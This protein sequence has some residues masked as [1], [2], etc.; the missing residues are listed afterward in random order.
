M[1]N[2]QLNFS[3]AYHPQIDGQTEAVNRS[4]GNLLRCLVGEH[5]KSWDKKLSQAEFAHNHAV[6]SSTG[7]SPFQVV[8]TI[9]PRGPLNLLPFPKTVIPHRTT[10]D[11]VNSLQTIHEAVRNNLERTTTKYKSTADKKKRHMEF[12]EGD[13]VWAV[14]TKERFPT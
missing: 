10:L 2:T 4:L 12:N 6:N 3:S 11:F 5:M 13:L 8:Y 9:V 14:L 7:F 1:V